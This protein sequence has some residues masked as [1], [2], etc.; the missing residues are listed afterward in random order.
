ME[1]TKMNPTTQYHPTTTRFIPLTQWP[2]HHLWPS[3]S[4][5]RYLVFH[6]K[7]NGFDRVIRR[8]GGRV[9]INE[10]AFFEWVEEQN[11][12]ASGR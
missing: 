2:K 4:G 1:D 9:L 12:K 6:A 11:K 7:T 5:L 10:D 3:I 8:A